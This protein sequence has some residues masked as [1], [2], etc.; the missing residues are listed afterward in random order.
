MH[1]YKRVGVP[2]ASVYTS[3]ESTTTP[4]QEREA[5][6]F[7]SAILMPA[8]LLSRAIETIDHDL[9]ED[10][11]LSLATAFGVSAQAMSI[12]LQRLNLLSV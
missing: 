12:R 8:P 10:D 1:V 4:E 6:L 3:G 2:S 5:N 7:A 11:M 9:D